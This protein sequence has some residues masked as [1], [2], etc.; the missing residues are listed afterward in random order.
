M[1]SFEDFKRK[2]RLR[3]E[4][5]KAAGVSWDELVEIYKDYEKQK[6]VLEQSLDTFLSEYFSPS[7]IR[8]QGLM[9]HSIGSRIKEPEHLIEKIVRKKNENA[10][11]YEKC[12]VTNYLKFITDTVGIR[13]LLVYKTDWENIH[14]YLVNTIENDDKKY[15]RDCIRDFD[16]DENHTYISEA[17]KVHVRNGDKT[18]IYDHILTPDRVLS[19]K[20]YRSVHYIIKYRGIYI[21]IQVRTLFEEGWGEVDHS[22]L[23]PTNKDNRLFVEYTELLN[24][25]SG[26]ADEMSSFFVTLKNIKVSE[27]TFDS[28]GK[29]SVQTKEEVKCVGEPT[30][31]DNGVFTY[32][33]AISEHIRKF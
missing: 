12:D 8:N 11:K 20:V 33:N 25:L 22:I 26:L 32:E 13:I 5:F 18:D 14:N 6:L 31:N 4:H 16:P 1:I 24:R 28:K 27:D 2:Y 3:D 30:Q 21:E 17:P 9:V 10:L 23:Y 29:E 7:V 19:D 15:I